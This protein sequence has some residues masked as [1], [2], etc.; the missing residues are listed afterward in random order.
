METERRKEMLG[1]RDSRFEEVFSEATGFQPFAYQRNLAC[2]DELP[3]LVRVP[4]GAGKTA[5]AVL[6]WLYRRRFHPDEQVR[7]STPRRLVYCLPMRVLVEQTADAV[8]KWVHALGLDGEVGVY[9]LMGGVLEEDWVRRPEGDAVLVGTMDMLLSRA[10]NRGYVAARSRW[11]LEFGLLNN[12]CLWVLDEVQLM[13]NGLATSAQLAAFRASFG[14]ARPCPS[15]WMSATVDG[16]WLVT[17]DHPSPLRIL[18]LPDA[19]RSGALRGRLQA[20]KT[21]RELRVAG[22]PEGG[23]E[24]ILER[25]QPGTITL[26]VLNTVE[27]ARRLHARLREQAV[28]QGVEVRLL[29]SRFRPPDRRA[30]LEAALAPTSGAGRIVVATQV[31]EA[32]VDVSAATLV[33]EL[34]PWT[35]LVQRFG[36]CNRF[37]EHAAG[38]VWWVDPEEAPPYDKDEVGEARD[39]LRGL[40]GSAVNP[41]ALE[42]LGPGRPPAVRHVIRR[43]DLLD[44]FD[45]EPDLA[46]NDVDVSR[47]IRDDADVD[48]QVFWRQ[49][50]GE[51]PPE[52]LPGAAPEELCPVPV[53]EV[54]EF[55]FGRGRRIA[56][57]TGYAWDHLDRRWRPLA[58]QEL[59]PG[60][61][62]LLPA[63]AGGYTKEAGWDREARGP[64][65]PLA[66]V[67]FAPEEAIDDDSPEEV[68]GAW[69]ALSDHLGHVEG[70][71]RALVATLAP[72]VQPWVWK[73]LE[74]AARWHDVG[75]A[76]EVFQK[77]LLAPLPDDKRNARNAT[78]WA[79]STLAR[80]RLDYERRHFRHELASALA[81]LAAPGESHGLEGDEL[82]LAAYLVAAHHG[83]V[84]T[85]LRSLRG[86]RRPREPERRFARGVWDGDR[87]GPLQLD[88]VMVPELRLDLGVMEAGRGP[89]GRPSWSERV[90]RLREQ[91]GPFVLAYLEALLRV[92]DWKAS[93]AESSE[94]GGDPGA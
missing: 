83:K 22:W 63:E 66:G 29:H 16:E 65:E 56:R 19:D 88:G 51:E 53:W 21:L 28:A 46:G 57:P 93:A 31:V 73:A 37:G 18:T 69:V 62:L 78:L 71:L 20:A 39:R 58:E 75:K 24:A 61:V 82:D 67:R 70:Q 26:V 52:D 44:L 60:I 80:R 76:H 13:G 14:T 48:V 36:R 6:G 79:K 17:V 85:A 94:G 77:A 45:T 92:A 11:P 90:L 15:L 4:T 89:D 81:L 40:E 74:V 59:R 25:H 5:A 49:W 9:Q 12:D 42:A 64:V 32:G 2:A 50:E 34:A 10:L 43:L 27:R 91:L 72:N 87:L 47:F 33:T 54:R 3:Q 41:E 86:E 68:A 55:L 35:S 23:A 7:R 38:Q 30:A 84:R 1:G 8:R